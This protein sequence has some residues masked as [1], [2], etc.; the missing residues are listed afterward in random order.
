MVL[1]IVGYS[2]MLEL[3][4]ARTLASIK[5]LQIEVLDPLIA[6][7]R[8]RTVK[9]TGD[10]AIVEFVSAVDAVLCA[11]AIQQRSAA[12]QQQAPSDTRIIFRIGI[13]LGDVVVDAGDL[14]GDGVNIAARLEALAT[15]GGICISDAV[16]RQLAGKSP[17]VFEDIGEQ[18]LKN[19]TRPVRVW[20]WSETPAATAGST[21]LALPDRPSIAVLPFDN[22]SGEAEETYFS[23]GLT[24]EIIT[25]LARF[26]SI[27]VIARNSSFAFRGGPI[28]IA[29]IGRK[30]GVSYVLE[31][32]IRRAGG[33]IRIIAQLIE[34]A[35]GAHLW[36]ERYDRS[37]DDIFAVQDD[38]SQMIV[39]TLVGRIEESQLQKSLRKPTVSLAAYDCVLRGIA[40]YR[41][42]A[43]DDNRKA[44][45]MFER[46]AALDPS[47]AVAHA[48][49]ARLK[50]ALY[51]YAAAPKEVLEDAFRRARHALELD[52]HEGRCHV[53][54]G[55]VWLY[56]REFETAEHHYR[57]AFDLNPNNADRL[58]G[59]GYVLALRGRSREA[60]DW[61]E[62]AIRLNP[63]HHAWYHTQRAIPL[64]SLGRYAEAVNDF[65]RV[66][67]PG[68]WSKAR[69][70]ACYAQ[71][72]QVAEAK[73]ASAAVLRMRPGF[74]TAEFLTRDVLLERAE[75][76][77][78]LRDGLIKAGLPES[79]T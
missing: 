49:V 23:D 5:T 25:G 58:M 34:A 33:R 62:R 56:R 3:D 35:S 72:G 27:F 52:P 10:G 76:R 19:I 60:L 77:E 61:M 57:K 74:S 40:H 20:R 44:F 51:G 70:A 37:L 55:L 39:S 15:A 26:R 9:L 21:S 63:F 67:E 24:E 41:G 31:G 79:T 18:Q 32:S 38:V 46:A 50:L 14:F 43:D 2:R 30:L 53:A 48:Y 7:H 75:D 36:A 78:H 59:L 68:Y 28:G 29:E 12:R 65:K 47:Y 22:L 8:G 73:A 13:N 69:L 66:P 6:E 4:E 64:Y 45:E 1:D 17:L 54:L 71:L 16:Q 11:F 42:Y